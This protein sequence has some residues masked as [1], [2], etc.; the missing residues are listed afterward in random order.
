MLTDLCDI[1][2]RK[3]MFFPRSVS[4]VVRGLGSLVVT[5]SA[6]GAKEPG[7]QFHF[8]PSAFEFNS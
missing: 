6:V 2:V 3:L 1:V 4:D 8:H 5:Q 7:V